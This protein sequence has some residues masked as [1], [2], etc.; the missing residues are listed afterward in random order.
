MK[1]NVAVFY[2]NKKSL[3]QVY[4]V[5]WSLGLLKNCSAKDFVHSSITRIVET[6]GVHCTVY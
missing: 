1:N 4:D 5:F 6:M 3:L 2:C